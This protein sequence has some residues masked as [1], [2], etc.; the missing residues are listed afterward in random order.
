MTSFKCDYICK[1][2]NQSCSNLLRLAVFFWYKFG[3]YQNQVGLS[4]CTRPN[5]V[6]NLLELVPL[7]VLQ[8]YVTLCMSPHFL[9]I[10]GSYIS[11][12]LAFGLLFG[13]FNPENNAHDSIS[14]KD[15]QLLSGFTFRPFTCTHAIGHAANPVIFHLICIKKTHGRYVCNKVRFYLTFGPIFKDITYIMMTRFVLHRAVCNRRL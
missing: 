3:S 2:F 10:S 5:L 1:F 9:I 6:I 14:R 4:T 12:P 15:L 11:S 7:P 13:W 8:Y